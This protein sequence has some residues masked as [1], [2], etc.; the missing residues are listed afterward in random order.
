MTECCLGTDVRRTEN[1]NKLVCPV[2]AGPPPPSSIVLPARQQTTPI[3]PT[4]RLN[5]QNRGIRDR[6][7]VLRAE[8]DTG[9][10]AEPTA[11]LK[12]AIETRKGWWESG[13]WC[14]SGPGSKPVP[15]HLRLHRQPIRWCF[16]QA[17]HASFVRPNGGR[18]LRTLPAVR[19]GVR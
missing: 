15:Q 8:E 7:Q 2:P 18:L 3:V 14:G 13:A 4:H 1:K 17:L 9:G 11:V 6:Y 5:N 16:L 10:A 12:A 19:F